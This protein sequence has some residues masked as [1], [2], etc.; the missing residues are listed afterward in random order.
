MSYL[1]S[2]AHRRP[3]AGPSIDAAMVDAASVT[4]TNQPGVVHNPPL[5]PEMF[6]GEIRLSS[7][8]HEVVDLDSTAASSEVGESVLQNAQLHKLMF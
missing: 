3:Q 1:D 8:P 4:L 5:T 2:P 7:T 6:S